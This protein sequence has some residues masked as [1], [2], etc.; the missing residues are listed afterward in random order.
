[1]TTPEIVQ[2]THAVAEHACI[3]YPL[4]SGLCADEVE[5]RLIR[6]FVHLVFQAADPAR[7]R[8]VVVLRLGLLEVRLTELHQGE[9]HPGLPRFWIEVFGWL[10]QTSI[11]SIG[12]STF[13][14][15]EVAA[16]VAMIVNAAQ[17]A[18]SR[19]ASPSHQSAA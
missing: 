19:H 3:D 5:Q 9:R 4:A 1:M 12:C 18:G 15:A 8:T 11:D 10:N 17:E 14:E 6:A 13:D 7:P 16:A 2:F